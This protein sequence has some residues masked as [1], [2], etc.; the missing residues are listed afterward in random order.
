[1][2]EEPEARTQIARLLQDERLRNATPAEI[3]SGVESG[4]DRLAEGIVAEAAA[5]DD[6]SDRQSA[7]AFIDARL[8]FLGS[9]MTDTQKQRIREAVEEKVKSW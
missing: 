7:V 9:L 3:Q 4:I 2:A 8:E 5:S 1:M 6:V